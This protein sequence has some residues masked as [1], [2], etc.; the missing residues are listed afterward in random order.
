VN[1]FSGAGA[2]ANRAGRLWRRFEAWLSETMPP[3]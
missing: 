1:T 2:A 3:D